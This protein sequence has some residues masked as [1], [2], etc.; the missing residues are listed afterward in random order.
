MVRQAL[1]MVRQALAMV[2]QVLVMVQGELEQ[3]ASNNP[4][5]LRSDSR[6]MHNRCPGTATQT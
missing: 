1:A 4:K 5:L 6:Q 2:Q 3:I